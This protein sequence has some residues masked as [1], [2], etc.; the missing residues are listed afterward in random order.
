MFRRRFSFNRLPR[1]GYLINKSDRNYSNRA[2]G[3]TIF[4]SDA[5][6]IKGSRDKSPLFPFLVPGITTATIEKLPNFESPTKHK[7]FPMF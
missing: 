3:T 4:G 2:M 6:F 1:F 5:V 7:K